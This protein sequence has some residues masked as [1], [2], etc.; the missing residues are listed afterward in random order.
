MHSSTVC[1]MRHQASLAAS[2]KW[3]A[4][5]RRACRA[6]PWTSPATPGTSLFDEARTLSHVDRQ[7]PNTGLTILT[8]T[9]NL[10]PKTGPAH[11]SVPVQNWEEEA[12]ED[13]YSRYLWFALRCSVFCCKVQRILES[14][15]NVESQFEVELTGHGALHP[16]VFTETFEWRLFPQMCRSHGGA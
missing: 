12:D 5:W 4:D 10:R 8:S 1:S 2:S 16:K 9:D 3:S 6:H 15:Q 11:W 14:Q 7:T 13:L